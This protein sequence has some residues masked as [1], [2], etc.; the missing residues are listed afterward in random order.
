MKKIL[1]LLKIVLLFI[2]LPF[3]ISKGSKRRAHKK[4]NALIVSVFF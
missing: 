1:A 3:E 2:T 4:I